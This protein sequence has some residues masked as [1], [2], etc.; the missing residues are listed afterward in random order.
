MRRFVFGPGALVPPFEATPVPVPVP[1]K[2]DLQILLTSITRPDGSTATVIVGIP[3]FDAEAFNIPAR[4]F[5]VFSPQQPTPEDTPESFLTKAG[6]FTA[7]CDVDP[8]NVVGQSFALALGSLTP[9][10]WYCQ[11]VL[12]FPE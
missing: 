6:N 5:A 8:G 1:T 10:A 7:Q 4:V 9:D 2:P 11:T 3:P 12:E